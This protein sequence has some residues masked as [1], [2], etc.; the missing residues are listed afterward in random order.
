MDA[1]GDTTTLVLPL[2]I[3]PMMY[4]SSPLLY[5]TARYES[6]TPDSLVA[7]IVLVFVFTDTPLGSF[8]EPL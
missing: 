5:L 8:R 6:G 3:T 4:V 2:G 1:G 7:V